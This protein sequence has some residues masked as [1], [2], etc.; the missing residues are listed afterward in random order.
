MQN[1]NFPNQILTLETG[2]ALKGIPPEI[3]MFIPHSHIVS[4]NIEN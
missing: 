2:E 4:L 1:L 3:Q